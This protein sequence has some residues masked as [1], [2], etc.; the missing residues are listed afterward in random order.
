MML[1]SGQCPQGR[2]GTDGDER[3]LN[4]H[5]APAPG[6]DQPRPEGLW[7]RQDHPARLKTHQGQPLA[8][9]QLPAQS[10]GFSQGRNRD[11]AVLAG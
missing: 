6:R 8:V 5:W 11:V 1:S 2:A 7:L 3:P 10:C 4:P 9:P